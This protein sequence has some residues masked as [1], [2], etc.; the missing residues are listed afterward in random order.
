MDSSKLA[1]RL[2][3]IIAPPRA[4]RL[5]ASGLPADNRIAV[6]HDVRRTENR[7][8]HVLGGEWLRQDGLSCFVV[9]RRYAPETVYGRDRLA[10]MATRLA[11]AAAEARLVA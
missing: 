8:E 5:S 4:E 6:E 10:T 9:E 2:R 7:V 1:H 3:A 11:E